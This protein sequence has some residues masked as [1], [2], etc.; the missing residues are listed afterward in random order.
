MRRITRLGRSIDLLRARAAAQTPSPYLCSACQLQATS[1]S[2]TSIRAAR[3][4]GKVPFT[5]K[6]RQRI[7]GT[8]KPPGLEDPY[9]DRSVFDRTKKRAKVE[10]AEEREDQLEEAKP[11]PD[12]STYEPAS[13]WDG[14][15]K[16]GGFGNWWK[17]NWDPDHQFRGFL[18]A[19][20]IKDSDEVTAALHRAIVEVFALQQVGMPPKDI[21]AAIPGVDLT[22][23]VQ[24]SPTA[25]GA[26]LQFS[27]KASLEQVIQSLTPA[28]DDETTV[29]ENPTES[30][31][32][33]AAD[34]STIDPLHPSSPEVEVD[35]TAE[36]GNPTESEED[37][38]ADRSTVDP[39][40]G[41]TQMT[42]GELVASWDPSW[43]QI[44]LENPE[45]K[46]AIVKRTMQLTGLRIPDAAIMPAK[47]VK[48]LL[49]HLVKPPKPRKL[50]DALQQKEE[51]MNIPNVS[52]YA[53][54]VTPIDKHKSVG[55]WK[56]IE[57]RLT[58]RG[59]PVTGHEGQSHAYGDY[60]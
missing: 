26:T 12:L 59:L 8:D 48:G 1:F 30:E 54:R 29:K 42:Y 52:I 47:T 10:E 11:T 57:Q 17:E 33:V 18:P 9:G 34:R 2:T 49:A 40:S 50:V 16:V 56:V 32:D 53:K 14:L 39:L 21:S 55:R 28:V 22:H 4:N 5:E 58:E 41:S 37:V 24:I 51:L 20:V 6:I 27:Q 3:N 13:T 31:E 44:S 46:F 15:E 43:L 38:A 23:E 25:T 60:R 19:E 7:W 45:I 36:K 35:E